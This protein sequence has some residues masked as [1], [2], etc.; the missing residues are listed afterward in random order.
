MHRAL[1][2][3]AGVTQA[4]RPNRQVG[5]VRLSGPAAARRGK[6]SRR[7]SNTRKAPS[8]TT[9]RQRF[10]PTC[11]ARAHPLAA[12]AKRGVQVEAVK[13]ARAH[14][15]QVVQE[16]IAASGSTPPRHRASSGLRRGAARIS[17]VSQTVERDDEFEVRAGMALTAH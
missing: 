12:I 15:V 17:H 3:A 11:A 7:A 1:A 8:A 5:N 14:G 9:V 16:A 10:S 6:A 2:R 13:Q 4:N